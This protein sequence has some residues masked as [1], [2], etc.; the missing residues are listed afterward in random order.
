M[1]KNKGKPFFSLVKKK[2]SDE[3]R[4]GKREN[5][6]RTKLNILN[7]MSYFHPFKHIYMTSKF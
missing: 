1:R 2:T 6:F 4:G 3:N 7:G 5:K